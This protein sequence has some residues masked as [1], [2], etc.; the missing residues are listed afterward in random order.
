MTQISPD[1]IF[2]KQGDQFTRVAS[3]MALVHNVLIRAL[4]TIYLQAPCVS[5]SEY[6]DFIG[7]SIT[8]VNLLETHHKFED[9]YF[10]KDIEKFCEEGIMT[11]NVV[12]HRKFHC[13]FNF[14]QKERGRVMIIWKVKS[15][16]SMEV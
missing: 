13:R 11:Q 2:C 5:P 3:E 12:Q 6:P 15:R 4:N 1:L 10:F 8:W 9:E 7:Y 16:K 14:F